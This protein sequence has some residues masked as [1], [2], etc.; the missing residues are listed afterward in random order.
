MSSDLILALFIH[1][2]NTS[3]NMFYIR[4]FWI[5]SLTSALL[6]KSS[7][8]QDAHN[9]WR[10]FWIASEF[11]CAFLQAD[12]SPRLAAFWSRHHLSV[13]CQPRL[14]SFYIS[15]PVIMHEH[16]KHRRFPENFHMPNFTQEGCRKPR[17]IS[18]SVLKGV[19][20]WDCLL[21]TILPRLINMNLVKFEH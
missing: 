1:S 4:E 21:S 18:Q 9:V 2:Y 13:G 8:K 7:L 10:H 3:L 5:F 17:H 20:C 15:G 6:C 14:K 11:H 16:C 12:T 19:A